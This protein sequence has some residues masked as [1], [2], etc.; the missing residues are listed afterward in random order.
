M[1]TDHGV[2]LSDAVVLLAANVVQC[3]APHAMMLPREGWERQRH[4]QTP[5][6][7]L[8]ARYVDLGGSEA[9]YLDRS[10]TPSMRPWTAH[11][12]AAPDM[13]LTVYPLD[14]PVV[15]GV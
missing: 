8:I 15:S 7:L 13:R 6:A 4:D 11:H 3:Q 5:A 9:V 1:A 14:L 12:L 10:E 2:E